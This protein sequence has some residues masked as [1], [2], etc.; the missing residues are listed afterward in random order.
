[1]YELSGLLVLGMASGATVCSLSCLPWFGP[2]L[3]GAGNGFKDGLVAALW[4]GLGKVCAYSALGGIAAAIGQA[5][6]FDRGLSMVMGVTLLGVALTMPLAARAGCAGRCPAAGKQAPLF[7]LGIVSSVMPCPPLAGV[8]LLAAN[9]GVVLG[10]MGYGFLFGIG[11]MASPMLLLG[12]GVGLISERIRKEAQGL[13]PYMQGL[14]MLIMVVMA[15]D[16]IV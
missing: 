7:L 16:M 12:G 11:M 8:F 4:F 13:A 14:A 2:Y 15:V 5:V 1:M 6:A 9:K 10:G 3:M